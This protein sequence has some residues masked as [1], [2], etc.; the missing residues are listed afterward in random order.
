M[1]KDKEESL[2]IPPLY[3]DNTKIATSS[4]WDSTSQKPLR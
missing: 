1:Q 4:T 2:M 3:Q